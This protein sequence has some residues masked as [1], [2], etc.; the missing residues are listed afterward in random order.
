MRRGVRAPRIGGAVQAARRLCLLALT[1]G[2]SPIGDAFAGAWTLPQGDAKTIVA[3]TYS[4]ASRDFGPSGRREPRSDFRKTE[5][6]AYGE[7]GIA[8]EVTLTFSGAYRSER[9]T[10]V[11]FS[12]S[13][14]GPTRINA[15]ARIRLGTIDETVF[16]IQPLIEVHA[17]S[18]TDDTFG[19]RAGDV[20]YEVRLLVGEPFQFLGID[21][22]V[23]SQLG[24]RTRPNGRAD[25][26]DI[27]ITW[28]LKPT[29]DWMV[30]FQSFN[31]VSVGPEAGPGDRI[32][33][34]KLSLSLVRRVDDK[35]SVGATA[36]SAVAGENIVAETGGGLS[37]WLHL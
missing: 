17:A 14:V 35:L 5:I 20:D 11:G 32:R 26:A 16:S 6:S 10:D 3:A 12:Q 23:D 34:H 36:F 9:V 8:D 24:Y 30:L 28:G 21:G 25:Q 37:V 29:P 22:F 18:Q 19:S 4:Q 33:S 27:D 15:G 2:L 13:R 1:L 31:F 7:F